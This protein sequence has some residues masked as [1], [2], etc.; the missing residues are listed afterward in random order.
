MRGWSLRVNRNSWLV[1]RGTA[2]SLA[3]LL[4]VLAGWQWGPGVLG[5]PVFIIPPLSAVFEEFLRMLAVSGLMTHTG[6]TAAEG[7]AGFLAGGLL[8]AFFGYVLGMSPTAEVALS[9]HI[10]ALQIAPKAAFAP[11][12]ILLIGFTVF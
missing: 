4:V 9:P 10:L 7:V 2:A 6:V 5:I 12:F 3:L 1:R 11:P 8:C